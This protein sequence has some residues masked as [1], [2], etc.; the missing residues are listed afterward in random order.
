MVDEEFISALKKILGE[1][2]I[3]EYSKSH[4][5]DWIR[6]ILNFEKMKKSVNPS[7]KHSI[8]LPLS[9]LMAREYKTFSGKDIEEA[10]SQTKVE[11][12][13][14][15]F[16][17]G[18][19]DI[20]HNK[21]QEIFQQVI[22][23]IVSLVKQVLSKERKLKKLDYIFLVGGFSG[24]GFLQEECLK[25]FSKVAPVLIPLSAQIAVLKGAVS[26]GH[27][28]WKIQ[29]RISRC[30]YGCQSE[31]LFDESKHDP[32]KMIE[33]DGVKKCIGLFKPFVYKGDEISVG[34]IIKLKCKPAKPGDKKIDFCILSAN[35]KDVVYIDEPGVT[36]L[37]HITLK[38]KHGPLSDDLE[39]SVTFGFTELFIKAVDNKKTSSTSK[40]SI[41]FISKASAPLR[42]H[43][44]RKKSVYEN[45]DHQPPSS[46]SSSDEP[47]EN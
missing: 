19:I 7:D 4:P 41:D 15:N 26:F 27:Q 17:N 32:T 31:Q 47:L 10:F 23:N 43:P 9:W 11:G 24:N 2:F 46:E 42:Y 12:F 44:S 1:K 13:L 16:K 40:T 28:P 14:L 5:E 45:H 22:K 38:S 29:S 3:K 33:K 8:R 39:I 36:T 6:F 35:R 25:A 34:K 37:G 21:M 30:T 20:E 18:T